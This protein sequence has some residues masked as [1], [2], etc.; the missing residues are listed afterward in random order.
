MALGHEVRLIPPAYV[1]PFVKRHKSGAVDAEAICEVAQRRTMRFVPVKSEEQ[2]ASALVFRT[3]DLLV[4]QRTQ[5]VNAMSRQ[6]D[7]PASP[8]RRDGTLADNHSPDRPDHRDG[9]DRPC[10]CCRDL[11][12]GTRLRRLAGSDTVAAIDRRQTEARSDVED[13]RANAAP[14]A[15]YRRQRRRQT[16][17]A[18]RSFQG[19]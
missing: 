12:L 6:G 11:C 9:A 17:V 1:K 10:S 14:P 19:M 5:L 15:D 4:R 8:R 7:D 13:G 2:Q 3:R 18:S 16:G